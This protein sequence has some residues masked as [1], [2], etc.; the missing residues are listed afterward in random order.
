ML[1]GDQLSGMRRTFLKNLAL[2]ELFPIVLLVE[3]GGNHSRTRRFASI[4]IT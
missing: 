4:G 2:L 1:R 3:L